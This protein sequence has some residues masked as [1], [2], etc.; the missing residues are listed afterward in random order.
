MDLKL[1]EVTSLI[2]FYNIAISWL[3]PPNGFQVNFLLRESASQELSVLVTF[4]QWGHFVMLNMSNLNLVSIQ[5]WTYLPSCPEVWSMLSTRSIA[6]QRIIANKTNYDF[7]WIVIYP[8]DSFIQ[9]L[10]NLGLMFPETYPLSSW[11][12]VLITHRGLDTV[13]VVTPA[14]QKYYIT[15]ALSCA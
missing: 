9:P 6:I 12:L 13:D 8:V 1:R 7:H 4:Y 14:R 2:I 11:S 10:N 15:N 3:H 5:S